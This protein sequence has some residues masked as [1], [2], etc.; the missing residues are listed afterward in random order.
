MVYNDGTSFENLNWRTSVGGDSQLDG[1]L[2]SNYV[3]ATKRYE[4]KTLG[5]LEGSIIAKGPGYEEG[6]VD[7]PALDFEIA[8]YR[9]GSSDLANYKY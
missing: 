8:G 5:P 1:S 4:L 7:W 3:P 6:D 9:M 2:I